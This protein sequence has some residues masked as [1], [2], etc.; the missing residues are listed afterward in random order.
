MNSH[1]VRKATKSDLPLI[2][3]IEDDSF[4]DPYPPAL[5]ERLQHEYAESFFVAETTKHK[6]VGYCVASEKAGMAHLISIG[7][8]SEHRRKGAGVALLKTLIGWLKERNAAELWLEVNAENSAAIRFYEQFGFGKVMVLENYY[9]DGSPALRMR[10][11]M[12]DI[13]PPRNRRGQKK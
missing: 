6:I 7:V 9:A 3:V 12:Q 1:L 2:C 10:L 8:L 11:T 4:P 5:I 13:T